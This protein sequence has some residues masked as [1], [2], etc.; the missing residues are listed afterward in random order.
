[1]YADKKF[2]Y[3]TKEVILFQVSILF[4]GDEENIHFYDY[5]FTLLNPFIS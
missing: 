1:M 5:F 4:K 2:V 3:N